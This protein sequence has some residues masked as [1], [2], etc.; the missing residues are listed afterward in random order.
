MKNV[1]IKNKVMSLHNISIDEALLLILINN[2]ANLIDI[3]KSLIDKGYI[4]SF[5]NLGDM[6]KDPN[7]LYAIPLSHLTI[8]SNGIKLLEDVIMDSDKSLSKDDDDD[9]NNLAKELKELFPKGKKDGTNYYWSDGIQ[10][11]VRRLRLFFKKYGNTYTN[12][13]I[14]QAADKYIKGFNGDYRYMKLLKYFIFKEKLGVGGDIEGES[15]LIN[16]IEN[17]G[18]EDLNDNWVTTLK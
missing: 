7:G 12:E 3:R 10:L 15:E 6:A 1:N 5:F 18:Q 11:I 16:Y 14:L 9:I 2:K 13:Q 4:T 8:T 17:N